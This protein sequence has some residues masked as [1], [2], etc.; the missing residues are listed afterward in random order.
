MI[1]LQISHKNRISDWQ[2]NYINKFP[3]NEELKKMNIEELKKLFN[4]CPI[5]DVKLK[6]EEITLEYGLPD[7]SAEYIKSLDELP[8]ANMRQF[9]GCVFSP[10]RPQPK[11]INVK[12]CTKCRKLYKKQVPN[13]RL[14]GR[15]F[16]K[17]F[18]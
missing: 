10:D 18:E 11:T 14:F 16:R 7:V 6:S 9:G 17:I 8:F 5:H 2:Q 3:N 1:D 12:Y 15:L 4:Y 13:Q